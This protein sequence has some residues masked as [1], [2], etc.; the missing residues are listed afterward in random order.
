MTNLSMVYWEQRENYIT[1][2]Q[3]FHYYLNNK[4][5][6][7]DLLKYTLLPKECQGKYYNGIPLEIP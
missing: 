2:V 1:R 5:G 6:M 7:N 3:T 4:F